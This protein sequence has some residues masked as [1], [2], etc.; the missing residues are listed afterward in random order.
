MKKTVLRPKKEI[1]Q[2]INI[3]QI[4]NKDKE[5]G[6]LDSDLE[7]PENKRI[8]ENVVKRIQ[9]KEAEPIKKIEQQQILKKKNI[10]IIDRNNR[11]MDMDK[12]DKGEKKLR[13]KTIDRG[14]K[15]KNIQ[16]R[17]IIYSKKNIE[18]H[19]V[20][21]LN[22]SYDKPLMYN[23]DKTKLRE[24]K[25]KV[26]VTYKSSCDNVKI[27][28]KKENLKKGKTVIFYHCAEIKQKDLKKNKNKTKV[29]RN[30][31][32]IN[33]VPMTRTYVQKEKNKLENINQNK[34]NTKQ[35]NKI[36]IENTN[37][38]IEKKIDDKSMKIFLLKNYF[39]IFKNRIKDIKSNYEKWFE[40]HCEKEN[41]KNKSKNRKQEE[42]INNNLINYLYPKIEYENDI[43]KMM[44]YDEW[45]NRNCEKSENLLKN[46]EEERIKKNLI[47][48]LKKIILDEKGKNDKIKLIN[49]EMDKYDNNKKKE[50]IKNLKFN[51]KDYLNQK[52][53]N[54]M[55]EICNN[56]EK[57][58]NKKELINYAQDDLSKNKIENLINLWEDEDKILLT[59]DEKNKKIEE[60][61][62]LF[63]NGEKNKLIDEL[64]KLNKK[65][66]LEIIEN[67]KNKDTSKSKEID[68]LNKLSEMKDKLE[69]LIKILNGNN[70]ET[71]EKINNNEKIKDILLALDKNT[72]NKC[73][74]YMKIKSNE[75]EG[76]KNDLISII[77]SLPE[78]E[79]EEKEN[80]K[81]NKDIFNYS[82]ANYNSFDKINE[83]EINIEQEKEE[84][85]EK[86]KENQKELDDD[87]FDIVNGIENDEEKKRLSED[88]FKEVSN[89]I[90]FNLYENEEDLDD[91]ELSEVVNLINDLDNNDKEKAIE[92]LK[93]KADN[94]KKKMIFSKLLKKI[95]LLRNSIKILKNAINQKK[96]EKKPDEIIL[97][98]LK[99]ESSAGLVEY[100]DG[101]DNNLN[102]NDNNDNN[103][104]N[105]SEKIKRQISFKGGKSNNMFNNLNKNDFL[106]QTGNFQTSINFMNRTLN[107]NFYFDE[108]Y[109]SNKVNLEKEELNK[110]INNI[111]NDLFEEK[112]KP[113]ARKEERK[114]EKENNE[115]LKEIAKVVYSLSKSDK[116]KLFN[117]LGLKAN[118]DF[119]IS[120]LNKLFNLVKNINNIQQYADNNINKKEEE[121]SE[122]E[123]KEFMDKINNELFNEEDNDKEQKLNEISEKISNLNKYQKNK[124]MEEL[125]LK[126]NDYIFNTLE[127][128]IKESN[129]EKEFFKSLRLRQAQNYEDKKESVNIP[130]Q[131]EIDLNEDDLIKI[132]EAIFYQISLNDKI[133]PEKIYIDEVENYLLKK[134]EENKL[135][136]IIKILNLLKNENRQEILGILTC[137]LENN[138]EFIDK[139]NEEMK[140][141]NEIIEKLLE[142]YKNEN[143]IKEFDDNKLEELAGKMMFDLMNENQDNKKRMQSINKAA[144][145]LINLN[146]NDQ[147]K[148]LFSLYQVKKNKFQK[149]KINKLNDLIENLNYMRLYL[150]RINKNNL[151]RELDSNE[152]NN[153]KDDVKSQ[154]F[155]DNDLD[156]ND[157]NI[158]KIALRLSILNNKDQND[159]LNEINEKANEFNV[160]SRK[161]VDKLNQLV[162][163]MNI[164]KKF[165]TMVKSKKN[166]LLNKTLT[167][168]KIQEL[169]YNLNDKLIKSKDPTNWTEKLLID[170]N[171]ERKIQNLAESINVLDENSKRKTIGF[172][173]QKMVNA[174]QKND[175]EK[176]KNSIIIN[177]EKSFNDKNTSTSQ[178]YMT[179][180]IGITDLNDFELN[181]LIE[182]FSK[183]LFNED[184]IDNNKREENLNLIANLIKELDNENQIKVL[185][186]LEKNPKS[187]N[188]DN[189]KDLDDL[190]VELNLLKDGIKEKR[191]DR[192]FG[193]LDY[194]KEDLIQE[195]DDNDYN[196]DNDKTMTVEISIDED[197][198]EEDLK[199][200]C[201]VFEVTNNDEEKDKS[202][203]NKNK[204]KNNKSINL[205]ASSFSKL[206]NKSQKNI[207]SK[208]EKRLKKEEEKNQLKELL[209]NIN[210]LNTC[211]KIGKELK[212]KKIKKE[213]QLEKEIENILKLNDNINKNLDEENINKLMKELI[214]YLFENIEIDF[215]KN[216]TIKTYLIETT[217]NEK[218]WNTTEKIAVL[219]D[220]DKET[221]LN[222]IKK[223]AENEGDK[224]YIYNKLCKYINIL[225]KIID[226]KNN[227]NQKK[228]DLIEPD[229]L[230]LSFEKSKVEFETLIK[231]LTKENVE[232]SD[233]INVVNEILKLD[234]INQEKFL[235]NL[236]ETLKSNHKGFIMKQFV[237][238]FN[239]KKTQKIFADK[240]IE[241]YLKLIIEE[242]EKNE[243][244]YGIFIDNVEKKETILLKNPSELKRDNFNEMKNN[245]FEDFKI[246]RE[247]MEMEFSFFE[248]YTKKKERE[249][250]LE[251]IA[252]II[253][254]LHNDDKIKILDEIKKNFDNPNDNI[255]YNE[256]LEILEKRTR[257]FNEEK[258]NRKKET[259]EEIEENKKNN[260]DTLLYSLIDVKGEKNYDSMDSMN[261]SQEV[262]EN[263]DNK[264]EENND[265]L[266]FTFPKGFLET[267]EIY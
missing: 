176:L 89:N 103:Q 194:E 121:L 172:L 220:N 201:K 28:N 246:L 58:L 257:K 262:L 214:N 71:K 250:K 105:L 91:K 182:A 11:Y 129:K 163:S 104:D 164:A 62:N 196:E 242:K 65:D 167:D 199:D 36:K 85:K 200:L 224:I 234:E 157:K 25:G 184:I 211:K 248:E 137:A 45:F 190:I 52:Q 2:N 240:V 33:I 150:F 8:Y 61:S 229:E 92:I 130:K 124:I 251:D 136:E 9:N 195:S 123:F 84:E 43:N 49:E 177:N 128:K 94:D 225:R 138:N 60:I 79:K 1:K 4:Q 255:L 109:N 206:N 267:Q 59:P 192:L 173:S 189:L 80:S 241:R 107:T 29:E 41:N 265:D 6:Y 160:N 197:I 183:D 235:N 245:F 15:Y 119:K 77:N 171:E 231:R 74:D 168:D 125:K 30:M 216:E 210:Q 166:K 145:I 87:L 259:F 82:F 14:G 158:D 237:K 42:K 75:D 142:E 90:I 118:N 63:Q 252:N 232:K 227:I 152:L 263:K 86:E 151:E 16:S 230:N 198:N 144:N 27:R 175:I 218:I 97:D 236:K 208:L 154:L 217:K 93:E 155:N 165:S 131:L 34:I 243:Q 19:I 54:E 10:N 7:D 64:S 181:L 203:E 31:N 51:L 191:D 83:D 226:M 156:D 48:N 249:K 115:K 12:K 38:N 66:K 204:I 112:E 99:T 102:N 76:K 100:R 37:Q 228:N 209:K 178:Y 56:I 50:I 247:E 161:S 55:R 266:M 110:L 5:K 22:V 219:S 133:N 69:N 40:K 35:N 233:I 98:D 213:E 120:Q 148:V 67:L 179:R 147:E 53:L 134:E 222:E 239:E 187:K 132:S 215:N 153:I 44:P 221:I 188:N 143:N 170:K 32:N 113:L 254:T 78:E 141:K 193:Q 3:I 26:K 260:E 256:F 117:K 253:N 72:K 149:E 139:L 73:I 205:L 101:E 223:G 127:K 162:K 57:E 264:I 212:D 244:K 20:E 24:P 70:E 261:M 111:K 23:K 116:N 135:N 238:I 47:N 95:K 108:D 114:N 39:R 169:A 146:K 88:E 180:S 185:T 46:N 202:R 13:R 17:Y 21:P 106:N 159:I 140:I 186:L 122:N 18:F 68:E 96:K 126:N 207:T 174:K 81:Y 258:R